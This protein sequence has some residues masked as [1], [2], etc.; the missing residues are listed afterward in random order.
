MGYMHE[1]EMAAAVGLWEEEFGRCVVAEG[2]NPLCGDEVRICV[3]CDGWGVVRAAAWTGYAC[4]LC[5][6]T[7]DYLIEKCIGEPISAFQSL[8]APSV[9]AAAGIRE[10]SRS[11]K[12]CVQLPIDTCRDAAG[13]WAA[14]DSSVEVAQS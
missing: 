6:M 8:D 2:S 11:R 7:C 10:V 1:S 9:C 12:G 5:T 14:Q 4:S 13:M 3:A